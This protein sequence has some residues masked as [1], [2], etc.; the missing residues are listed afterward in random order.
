MLFDTSVRFDTYTGYT[1]SD[2]INVDCGFTNGARFVMIK[3]TDSTGTWFV[4][5]TSHSSIVSGND[6][7]IRL[8][9]NGVKTQQQIILIR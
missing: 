6:P 5:D 7:Y 8:D 3:G 4:W 9:T 2:G 1:G